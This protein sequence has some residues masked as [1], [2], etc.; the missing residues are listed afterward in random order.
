MSAELHLPDLPDVAVSVGPERGGA[1]RPRL[2]WTE[3]VRM[4]MGTYLPLLMMV[5]LAGATW[6]LV[7]VSPAA[8]EQR[9]PGAM[10]HDAD[11]TLAHFSSQR[12]DASGR[13]AV[14]IEG[15]QLRHYPDTDELEIDSVKLIAQAP[16]G[17]ITTATARH[18]VVAGDGSEARLEGDA[19]V[20]SQGPGSEPAVS[21]EGQRLVARLKERRVSTDQPVRVR[22]GA[23][24][25]S[26]DGLDYDDNT[27]QLRLHGKLRASMQ[28]GRRAR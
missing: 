18:A 27:R 16:D 8:P 17:R 19:R 1:Q 23:S 12:Y 28:P 9:Q 24:E 3:R 5:A 4:G 21:L 11:Y 6:W 15:E 13:L 25:F 2:A 14:Q 7:K 26:A 20:L 22:Q 10:R